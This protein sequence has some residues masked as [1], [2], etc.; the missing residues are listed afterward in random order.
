MLIFEDGWR[1][2]D[3]SINNVFS[4][5]CSSDFLFPDYFKTLLKEIEVRKMSDIK[6]NDESN[7]SCA[8][9]AIC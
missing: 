4:T 2:A 3:G 7:A 6:V 5:A 8:W 1:P 9:P